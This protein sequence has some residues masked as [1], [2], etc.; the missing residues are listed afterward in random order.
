MCTR[1]D[2]KHSAYAIKWFIMQ[3]I[4]N[5][6]TFY[7]YNSKIDRR[8]STLIRSCAHRLFGKSLIN[9]HLFDQWKVTFIAEEPMPSERPIL[10]DIIDL[11]S[12]AQTE[13]S[14]QKQPENKRNFLTIV[15]SILKLI[16]SRLRKNLT[17][18]SP[19]SRG[20]VDSGR[21]CT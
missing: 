18:V 20:V 14:S 17:S 12:A 8:A 9:A 16:A 3:W 19:Y 21:H 15:R 2:A 13:R 5:F 10:S 4:L 11:W 7:I 1:T 6:G